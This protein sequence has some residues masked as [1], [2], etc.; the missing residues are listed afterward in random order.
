[1]NDI[2]QNHKFAPTLGGA[3][4]AA[5]KAGTDLTCGTEYKTLVDEVK[6]G[7]ISEAEIDRAL[8]GFSSHGSAWACSIPAGARAVLEDPDLRERLEPRIGSSRGRPP[9]EAIVLLKNEGGVLPLAPSVRRIAVI[10]PSADDPVAVLGNYNGISSKQVT[11]LEGIERQ[12]PAATVRYALGATYTGATPGARAV[13]LPQR[14]P[15]GRGAACSPSTSTTP[16][17][18]GS[19]GSAGAS[20]GR[21]STWRWSP[22]WSRPSV[23]RST[24]FAGPRR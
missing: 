24:R 4:V 15:T 17:S 5:V 22:P 21:T 2:Y 1:M 3:A 6:A 12:F 9:D 20:R 23:A 7:T 8:G 13:D 18:R 10:G 14:R 11:P 19:R 16:T